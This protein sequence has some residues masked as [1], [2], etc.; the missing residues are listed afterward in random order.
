MLLPREMK[1]YSDTIDVQ[2]DDN[3]FLLFSDTS[4]SLFQE[5]FV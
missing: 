5:H 2:Q 1:A 3:K 4:L